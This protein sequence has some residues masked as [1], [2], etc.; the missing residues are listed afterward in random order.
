[1]K[2]LALALGFLLAA[3]PSAALADSLTREE[4]SRL[5]RGETV[6]RPHTVQRGERR[7]VG[8]IGYTLV[9]ATVDQ[10]WVMS[11]EVESYRHVLP[12]TKSVRRVTSL[13]G[14]DLFVELSQGRGPFGFKYTIRIRKEPATRTIRFW[15]EPRRSHDIEDIF[16][17]FRFEPAGEGRSLLVYGILLNLGPGLTRDL[18]EE[19]VRGVMLSVPDRVRAYLKERLAKPR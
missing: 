3:V 2:R 14:P 9:D 17:Y 16:G 11:N 4:T 10:L 12:E 8:G 18:F 19:R 1:M 5:L 7:W 15:I 13:K 6:S